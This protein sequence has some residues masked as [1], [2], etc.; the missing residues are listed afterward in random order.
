M[1]GAYFEKRR[2]VERSP[3]AR[4]RALAARV[5]TLSEQLTGEQ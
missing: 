5:W 4:D 2:A 1:T 3:L